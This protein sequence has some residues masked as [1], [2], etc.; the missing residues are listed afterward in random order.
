MEWAWLLCVGLA[1]AV[2]LVVWSLC[3]GKKSRTRVA[4]VELAKEIDTQ[5]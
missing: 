1:I 2:C 4:G 5:R 3:S